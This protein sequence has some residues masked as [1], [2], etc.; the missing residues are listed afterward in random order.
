MQIN[1]TPS[2]TKAKTDKKTYNFNDE[3]GSYSD[4]D[5]LLTNK[6]ENTYITQRG[7]ISYRYNIRKYNFMAGLNFQQ[8]NLKRLFD[9][10]AFDSVV[11]PI[12]AVY[13][14]LRS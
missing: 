13:N 4:L 12:F 2:F 6:S 7:G 14:R 8:A 10:V 11:S 1:Y 3:T 5:T 9:P